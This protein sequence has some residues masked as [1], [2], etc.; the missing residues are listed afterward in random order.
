MMT[1]PRLSKLAQ[2]LVHYSTEVKPGELVQISG[3]TYSKPL[4]REVYREVVRAGGYPV[5][6]MQFAD[7]DFVFYSNASDAQLD[8]EN[9]FALY[10]AENFDVYICVFPDANP[11]VLTSID[12]TKKQR[13]F[14]ANKR[15]AETF[16]KRW[17]DG[18]LR[19]VGT[20]CPT[21]ALAQ[22]AHMSF[23]E[24]SEFV[25]DCGNLNDLDPVS[26][27]KQYSA[28]QQKICNRLNEC[29][30]IR[31]VG[32]DTDLKFSCKG[33]TW[34]NCDGHVNFP[35]GEVFTGPIEDS[36]E[37]T[38][39]F[40]Y[41]GI[42]YGQEIEDIFL[43][44]EKGKVIEA[45]AAKGQDLLHKLLETDQGSSYIGEVAI[46]T[47]ENIKRFT[48]NMLFDEKMGG[49]IHL[50]VGNGIPT[51]GSKNISAIH[52][53]MLKDMRKGGEIHADGRLIYRD[54]KFV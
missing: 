29:Q 52:W 54:G 22:E 46:G 25:F 30:T 2:L 34:M 14:R 28:E 38:I 12:A 21:Q 41:P 15:I 32:L 9:Q 10:D 11:H 33:R 31:Y 8:H 45:R 48:K 4:L 19:W 23:D 16:T 7:Q 42:F 40:T 6:R 26:Y 17:G 36:V 44:F 13:V 47:N 39:R 51:T 1:D 37:G 3:S 43:R 18:K 50:A 49:T 20:T 35:D 5:V 27:W 24:F 53:D